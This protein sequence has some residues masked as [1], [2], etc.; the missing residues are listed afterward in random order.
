M[1]SGSAGAVRSSVGDDVR[2]VPSVPGRGDDALPHR[3]P[4]GG[5]VP[6]DRSVTARVVGLLAAGYAALTVTFVVTGFVVTELVMDAW[7]GDVDTGVTAWFARHR[8]APLDA[9]TRV[10][11]DLADTFTVVGAVVGASAMLLASRL[12]RHAAVL[13][14]GLALELGV[15]LSTTYVVGRRRPTVDALDSV[16]S[17]ASFP[18]GHAAAAVVLYVGLA[19][20]ACSLAGHTV[21]RGWVLAAGVLAAGVALSR[22]YRGLHNPIDVVA[23]ALLGA[24]CLAVAVVV[25]RTLPERGERDRIE[26]GSGT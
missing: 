16:P 17:T 26:L 18:S 19:L 6:E 21:R 8:S 1:W 13:L 7:L 25:A 9:I 4:S 12:W 2:D 15:F 5:A 22:V 14:V 11:S 10:L 3:A 23:G 20:I 24:C